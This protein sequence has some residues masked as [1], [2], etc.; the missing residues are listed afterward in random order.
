MRDLNF[1]H[2]YYFW[3]VAKEGHLTR[4]AE[5]LHV[6]QS[7]LSSQIR[8]L[9]EQL[10][11]ELFTREGRSLRLTETGYLVLEYAESIFNLGSELLA[12]TE[13]GELQRLQRLRIGSVATLSR[14]FQENFLQPVIGEPG[15]KLVIRSASLEELLELLRVHKLDLILSNRAV[16][17]DTSTPWRCQQIAEQSVCVVGPPGKAARAFRFPRDLGELPLLLPG[18]G[19]EIRSQFDLLCSKH[20]IEFDPY[21][22]VDDMATL[23]LLARDSGGIAVVPEVV[24]QDELQGGKLQRYCVLDN[25]VERFYAITAKRHFELAALQTLLERS[26]QGALALG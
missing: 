3:M 17:T 9:Q 23:R 13:S 18:P 20:G 12:L 2:L 11:H 15:V 26:Q 10:G 16:P 1:H 14:N 5:K 7:A 8:Q 22:E 4:A 19:S 21:A 25:V 24:V 6:S